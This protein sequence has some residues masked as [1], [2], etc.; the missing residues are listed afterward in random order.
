[1]SIDELGDSISKIDK[2]VNQLASQQ[3]A[4][5]LEMENGMSMLTHEIQELSKIIRGE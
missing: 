3:H 4:R 5:A 1:M 2:R